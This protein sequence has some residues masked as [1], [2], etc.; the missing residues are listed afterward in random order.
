MKTFLVVFVLVVTMMLVRVLLGRFIRQ[1]RLLLFGVDF[2]A[3]GV[4]ALFMCVFYGLPFVGLQYGVAP[5]SL[6]GDSAVKASILITCIGA[7]SI[8]VSLMWQ[9]FCRD[10]KRS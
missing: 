6:S 3:C 5:T 8:L 10:K 2:F 7:A 1:R 9:F 4:V